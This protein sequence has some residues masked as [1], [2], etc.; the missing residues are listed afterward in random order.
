MARVLRFGVYGS[1]G[2]VYPGW[3]VGR[4]GSVWESELV[5]SELLDGQG[6]DGNRTG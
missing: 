6:W 1:L 2:M 4:G 3:R 5:E